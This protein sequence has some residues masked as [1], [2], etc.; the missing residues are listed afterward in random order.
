MMSQKEKEMQDT[1]KQRIEAF[2]TNHLKIINKG[3]YLAEFPDKNRFMT[4]KQLVDTYEHL[5]GIECFGMMGNVITKPFIPEWTEMNPTIRSKDDMDIFPPPL[6]CP[7]NVYNTWKP[8]AGQVFLEKC[9]FT[10]DENAITKIRKHILILCN[11]DE[12]VAGYFELWIA[13]MIQF[14]AIK[15][16]CPILISKE[17]AGKG[18]LLQFLSRMTGANKYYET[19]KPEQ[20]IWGSFNSVMVDAFLVNLNELSKKSTTDA[21]GVIKGLITDPAMTINTKGVSAYEITSYHRWI[22][23]TNNEDPMPTKKDDRRFWIIRSSDELVGNKEYFYDMQEMLKDDN[24]IASLFDYFSTLEG[25]EDFGKLQRPITEYQQNIQD[26]NIS[27]PERWLRDYVSSAGVNEVELL[28]KQIFQLFQQWKEANGITFEMNAIK[29]GLSL[30]NMNI[31]GIKKGRHTNKGET[32]IFDI[33][34][35]KKHFGVGCLI[36]L[37]DNEESEDEDNEK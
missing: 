25:A 34:K 7:E 28:G 22:I 19:T 36:G 13:Q 23:T 37:V 4:K 17:G 9:G 33:K 24:V 30:S 27:I 20:H 32:K 3:L 14:P 35:L 6:I 12:A 11:N 10:K 31:D 2:E 21:M 1:R 26:A 18:T 16:N 15:S 5:E 8:F 29:L